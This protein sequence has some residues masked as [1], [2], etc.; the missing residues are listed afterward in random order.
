MS[1]SASTPARILVGLAL[2]TLCTLALRLVGIGCGLPHH[3]EPD[4]MLVP[5]AA[6]FA[7]PPGTGEGLLCAPYTYYPRFLAWLISIAP[8]RSYPS[9]P[10]VDA[11]LAAHLAALAVPFLKA[12]I[13]IACLSV[14]AIPSSFYLARRF[15]D[16]RWS[17]LAAAFVATSL[18]ATNY[19]Q[20]ARPH[21]AMIGLMSLGLVLVLR[22]LDSASWTNY[23][24]AGLGAGLA[25]AGLHNGACVVLALCAAHWLAPGRSWLRFALSALALAACFLPSWWLILEQGLGK[26]AHGGASVG[27]QEVGGANYTG[28]GFLQIPRYLFGYE[29]AMCILA[30]LALGAWALRRE[31][32]KPLFVLAACFVPFVLVFGTRNVVE[33]RFFTPFVPVLALLATGGLRVLTGNAALAALALLPQSY[34]SVRLVVLRS[35]GETL[36]HAAQW[37]EAHA[38]REHD[39]IGLQPAFALPLFTRRADLEAMNPRFRSVWEL[40]QLA[41]PAEP[42]GAWD[43]RCLSREEWWKT[44]PAASVAELARAEQLR[45]GLGVVPTGKAVGHNEVLAGLR[46]LG[47]PALLLHP[48]EPVDVA[49]SSSAYELGYYAF[50]RVLRSRVWGHPLEIV[51]VK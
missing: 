26:G 28:L 1:A 24:L 5:H 43:L 11:G 39:A 21:G 16:P 35:Q 45:Y 47:E 30:L 38:D 27:G 46:T 8:G 41:L 48:C 20:Q 49:I 33:A 14:I 44:S 37:L 13:V 2:L 40:Y 6:W 36:C 18:L 12:R 7:R 3:V 23:A 9:V 19:A 25:L 10:P 42:A 29:P 15:F 22:L 4:V 50:E 17:L 34:A 51:R 31:R 32:G